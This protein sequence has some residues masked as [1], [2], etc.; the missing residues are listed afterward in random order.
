MKKLTISLIVALMLPVVAHAKRVIELTEPMMTVY[1]PDEKV[2]TGRMVVAFPG[3]GYH[4]LAMGRE[5]LDWAPFF[6]KLGI[7][8]AVVAYTMPDHRKFVPMND[9][10]AALKTVRDSAATWGIN[11]RDVGIMGSSAGGHL[12]ATVSTL[13][14]PLERPDFQ[15][16]LYPVISMQDDITNIITRRNLLGNDP[17]DD[18]KTV[19]SGEMAASWETPRAFIA[20]SDDDTVVDPRNA[21]RYYE[22]LRRSGVPASLHIY[23]SGN[24]G[25]GIREDF[26]YKNQM[27]EELRLWLESFS[28]LPDD[29]PGLQRVEGRP[30]VFII[31]DS[32]VKNEDRDPDSIWGWGS[33]IGEWLDTDAITIE[34]HA[35]PGRSARSYREEGLWD[36]VIKAVRPG[37]YVMIQF[38]H[39]DASPLNTGRC[40]GSLPGTGDETETIIVAKNGRRVD[41]ETYGAYLRQYIAD[42]KAAG[43]TPIIVTPMPRN[44]W[45][46]GVAQ[47]TEDTYAKW[48]TEIA[49]EQGVTL[50]D[51][52]ALTRASF[53]RIGQDSI[54]PYFKGDN[55][56]FSLQGARLNAANV[57]QG[58]AD[59]TSRLKRYLKKR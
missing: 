10:I 38:G 17:A 18:D 53:N 14:G 21:S 32:T 2:A 55:T 29:T 37:D 5:G 24:H 48:A 57:A 16:L 35:R 43:A 51:L 9:A 50:I 49:R 23:P 27:L 47:G 1:L 36:R 7:G 3:G 4:A 15:I 59:S 54:A 28:P 26:L 40:R 6:N 20:L 31:G 44:R 52:D 11:P 25:W 30:T 46:D 41:V 42:V 8:L 39:N 22:A 33:V 58:L 13:A 12:A 19:F 34:N 45:K 56:H